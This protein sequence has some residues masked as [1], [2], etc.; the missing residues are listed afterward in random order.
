MKDTL[1][2]PQW[3]PE[4]VDNMIL[5]QSL[6]WEDPPFSRAS[7]PVCHNC[8][9]RPSAQNN[10]VDIKISLFFYLTLNKWEETQ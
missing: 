10:E 9:V 7:K 8:W 3:L 1:Q 2:V 4:I 5:V 6:V